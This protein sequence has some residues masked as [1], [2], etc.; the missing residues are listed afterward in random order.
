MAQ[1]YSMVVNCKDGKQHIYTENTLDSVYFVPTKANSLPI[2]DE[3]GMP[4]SFTD[5]ITSEIDLTNGRVIETNDFMHVDI[6]CVEGATIY[7]YKFNRHT[8]DLMFSFKDHN[9]SILSKTNNGYG[10]GGWSYLTATAPANTAYVTIRFCEPSNFRNKTKAYIA[11]SNNIL[12]T[13]ISRAASTYKPKTIGYNGDSTGAGVCANVNNDQINNECVIYKGCVGGENIY[14]TAARQGSIPL[15][16]EPFTIPASSVAR[17]RSFPEGINPEGN[18]PEIIATPA[19]LYCVK[20]KDGETIKQIYQNALFDKNYPFYASI[21]GVPGYIYTIDGYVVNDDG[22]I[23]TNTQKHTYFHRL[24]PGEEIVLN[25][26]THSVSSSGEIYRNAYNINMMGTN[27]GFLNHDDNGLY[28]SAIVS[29]EQYAKNLCDVLSIMDEYCSNQMLVVGMFCESYY[30]FN[31]DFYEAYDSI[32]SRRFGNRFFN[33]RKYLM[34]EAWQELGISLSEDDMDNI[35]QGLAPWSL[36]GDGSGIRH[37][38]PH[39]STKA[40]KVL[41]NKILNKIWELGWVK[42]APKPL[43]VE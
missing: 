38:N 5:R 31:K 29:A 17:W 35:S 19:S 43:K 6:P 41:M 18:D 1:N 27:C 4:V 14:A 20:N 33:A 39:L 23:N 8:D 30:L 9:G 21:A 37:Y 32:C 25:D 26:T 15:V 28:S 24:E 13:L 2:T 42:K 22:T 12:E 10:N 16:I 36:F 7:I 11:I 34:E 40:N 3:N